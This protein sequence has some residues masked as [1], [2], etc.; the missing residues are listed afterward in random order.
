[1][2]LYGAAISVRAQMGED[3]KSGSAK[4]LA[5][6]ALSSL[7]AKDK[8]SIIQD[9]VAP[10]YKEIAKNISKIIELE[11]RIANLE[12]ARLISQEKNGAQLFEKEEE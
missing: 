1:M 10:N 2:E 4:K 9:K 5:K 8:K 7:T 11:A 12:A 3:S 6:Q